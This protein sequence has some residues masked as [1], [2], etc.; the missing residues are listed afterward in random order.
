MARR[1][2]KATAD[3]YVE[4]VIAAHPNALIPHYLMACYAYYVQDNPLI[5]DRLFDVITKRLIAE[6]DTLE[7]IHKEHITMDDLVAGTGFAIVYPK[8]TVGGAQHMAWLFER[9]ELKHHAAK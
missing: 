5:S 7:H 3:D 2:A 8:M 1:K 6:Y 9:G 4:G